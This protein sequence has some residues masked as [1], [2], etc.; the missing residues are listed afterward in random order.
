[1]LVEHLA[2]VPRYVGIASFIF[3]TVVLLA[4]FLHPSISP[5]ECKHINKKLSI[6]AANKLCYI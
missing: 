1:M 4:N 6:D 3:G 5:P 2:F